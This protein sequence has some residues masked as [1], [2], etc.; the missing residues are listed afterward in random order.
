MVIG[1]FSS[2]GMRDA[3]VLALAPSG[4]SAPGCPDSPAGAG[5]I[6]AKARG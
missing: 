4:L 6:A 2:S 1:K 5:K 3:P